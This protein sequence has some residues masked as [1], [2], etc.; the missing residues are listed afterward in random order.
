MEMVTDNLPEG[1]RQERYCMHHITI[2]V[3]GENNIGGF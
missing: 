2:H 1:C 3:T